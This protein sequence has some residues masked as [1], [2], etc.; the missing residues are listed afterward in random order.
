MGKSLPNARAS[1]HLC[2]VAKE[3]GKISLNVM[4]SASLPPNARKPAREHAL[5]FKKHNKKNPT[6]CSFQGLPACV[7]DHEHA[8]HRGVE[9]P[10]WE[11][12]EG[13]REQGCCPSPPRVGTLGHLIQRSQVRD[14]AENSKNFM[15]FHEIQGLG[16]PS[17]D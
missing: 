16:A 13:A 9:K 3:P 8:T 17:G 15:F 2:N 12:E 4:L 6:L 14:L 7:T 11:T 5:F 1:K 10:W